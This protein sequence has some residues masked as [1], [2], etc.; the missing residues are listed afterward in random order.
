M[1][2]LQQVGMSPEIAA[3]LLQT[4][5]WVMAT[6]LGEIRSTHGSVEAYLTGPAGMAPAAVEGLRRHL[7]D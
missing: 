1:D 5:R 6:V 2:T 7:L 4:P 3:G